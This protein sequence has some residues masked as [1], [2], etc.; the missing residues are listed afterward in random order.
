M[1]HVV[2]RVKGALLLLTVVCTSYP[3]EW[4]GPAA[5]QV[6]GGARASL[7]SCAY[8]PEFC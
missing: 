1:D 2:L 3:M 6:P 7:P 5:W 4:P 8:P